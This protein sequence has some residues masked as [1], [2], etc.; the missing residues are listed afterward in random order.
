MEVNVLIDGEFESCPGEGWFRDTIE[1]V[2]E[3]Q[4]ASPNAEVSLMITGQK[5][6]RELNR[7]YRGADRPTDV[8]AFHMT[9]A[10]TEDKSF[11]APPDGVLHLGE[12]II[13]YPQAALQAEEQQHS[14]KRELTILLVHGVLHLLGYDHEKPE[15]ERQM[16]EQERFVL[17][18]ISYD[19]EEKSNG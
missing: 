16:R 18:R 2:L 15:E 14:V 19:A 7:T 3:V 17:S 10:G 8:L 11:I 12:V 6:M 13:S 1:Q 5:R 4:G 9:E